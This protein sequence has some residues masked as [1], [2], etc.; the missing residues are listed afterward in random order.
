MHLVLVNKRNDEK[1]FY[2]M[3]GRLEL[4]LAL[5]FLCVG[6]PASAQV[7]SLPG[8]RFELSPDSSNSGSFTLA[9]FVRRGNSLEQAT[10]FLDWKDNQVLLLTADNELAPSSIMHNGLLINFKAK[11]PKITP[12]DFLFS[13]YNPLLERGILKEMSTR[14]K[15]QTIK[16]PFPIY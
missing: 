13:S 1:S 15:N 12:V 8:T 14:I 11:D 10:T 4:S 3:N 7:H 16:F 6:T 9:S 5:I 2:A